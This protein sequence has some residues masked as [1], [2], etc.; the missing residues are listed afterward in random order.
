MYSVH[1]LVYAIGCSCIIDPF[2]VNFKID[3]SGGL[4]IDI[5]NE[6]DYELDARI[7][8]NPRYIRL[9]IY[10]YISETTLNSDF[11]KC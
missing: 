1:P 6:L 7:T 3:N 9:Y 5:N 2:S 4:Y 8:V 11:Y 10:I